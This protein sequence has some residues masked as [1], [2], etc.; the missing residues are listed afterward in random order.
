[1]ADP[2]ITQEGSFR[3]YLGDISSDNSPGLVVLL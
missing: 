1:M 3:N 2:I